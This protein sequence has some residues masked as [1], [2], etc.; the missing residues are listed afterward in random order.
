M[1]D[2]SFHKG[3]DIPAPAGTDILASK[4]GTVSSYTASDYGNYIIIAH[5]DGSQ[6]LYA[7]CSSFIVRSGYVSQGQAIAKVGSTG[8]STGNHLHFEIIING[9]NVDPAPYVG[10]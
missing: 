6:T 2:G 1:R 4:A 5:G 10:A 7:H 3:I 9:S 8:R